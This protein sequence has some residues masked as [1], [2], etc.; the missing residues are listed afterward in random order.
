MLKVKSHNT[1]PTTEMLVGDILDDVKQKIDVSVVVQGDITKPIIKAMM[2][3]DD[4]IDIQLLDYND[5]DYGGEYYVSVT[6]HDNIPELWVEKAWSDET[7]RYLGS[8]SDF[9]Y[10]ASDVNTDMY[11]CLDGLGTVFSV[12]E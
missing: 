6:W 10:V 7:K 4:D 2:N 11:K 12:E 1:Y 5:F 3:I 9:Y 8:E